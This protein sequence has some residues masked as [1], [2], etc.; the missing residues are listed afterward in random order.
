MAVRFVSDLV[1]NNEDRFSHDAAHII[2][3]ILS[4]LI[5]EE[6]PNPGQNYYGTSRTAYLPDD[7]EGRKVL[8]LLQEAF[9]RRLVFTVGRSRTTGADNQVT[10]NDIHH[11]TC[12]NGGQQGY[13]CFSFNL[14]NSDDF[15][16]EESG[17]PGSLETDRRPSALHSW[18][19]RYMRVLVIE[20][21]QVLKMTKLA[22]QLRVYGDVSVLF[23]VLIDKSM[24]H[25]KFS[26][27]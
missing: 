6:H 18:V 19:S 14:T 23:V 24:Y 16:N 3:N 1:G 12:T 15:G 10:W 13:V 21:F 8:K 20:E 25:D 27:N 26:R 2:G 5:Q 9:K 17:N 11:K 22:Y 4:F 7:E